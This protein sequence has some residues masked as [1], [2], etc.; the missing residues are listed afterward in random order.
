[1]KHNLR[2]VLAT[3][4]AT[5]TLIA[6]LSMQNVTS[7]II[8]PMTASALVSDKI[9]WQ[10]AD[11][12]TLYFES[13]RS[14]F[15]CTLT[16]SDITVN[17]ATFAIPDNVTK[18]GRTFRVTSIGRNAFRNQKKLRSITQGAEH[19][20]SIESGAFMGCSNLYS[21]SLFDGTSSTTSSTATVRYIGDSA[22]KD[23]TALKDSQFLQNA[24]DIGPWAFWGSSLPSVYLRDVHSIGE[25]AFYNCTNV[26]SINIYGS[27]LKEIPNFA[28][29]NCCNTGNISLHTG[30]EYIGKSA[31]INCKK[32]TELSLPSTVKTID[33][34]AFMGCSKLKNVETVHIDSIMDHAFFNCPS[35]TQFKSSYKNTVLGNYSLGFSYTNKLEKN[36]SLHIVAPSG[37]TVQAYAKGN[38]FLFN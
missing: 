3:T 31:F 30:V 4:A 34:G 27:S 15:S 19:I 10:V 21:L 29:Y 25:A 16:G 13:D 5:L 14:N 12:I 38:G 11:G 32:V 2:R 18:Y 28:F 8:A 22:F 24:E 37:G 1:M 36:S 23:C 17:N 26:S 33:T 7:G 6:P 9:E 35:I 20:T